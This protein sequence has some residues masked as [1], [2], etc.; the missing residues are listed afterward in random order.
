VLKLEKEFLLFDLDGTLTNPKLGITKS[1]QYALKAFGI[2]IDDLD[3][4]IPC[5]GPPLRDSFKN[6]YAFSEEEAERAVAKYREYFGSQGIFE[7]ALY[8]GVPALLGE[9]ATRDKKLIVATSKPTVYAKKIL[10]HFGIAASFAFVSGSEMDGTRS[11]KAEVIRYALEN[12]GVTDRS[13]AIMIGDR[14]HDILGAKALGMDSIGV[15]YGYGS[16]EELEG[17][18]ADYIAENVEALSKLLCGGNL[19]A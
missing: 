2:V 19:N 9:Q 16:R 18:G 10:E 3:E 11:G 17:A 13:K 15:L 8:N 7:N 5:I 6:F 14:K 4:L 1:F 12:M